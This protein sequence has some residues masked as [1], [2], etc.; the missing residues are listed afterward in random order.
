MVKRKALMKSLSSNLHS[1]LKKTGKNLSLPDKKFLQVGL[2][3]PHILKA[4]IA[5]IAGEEDTA[6]NTMT[7]TVDV[8]AP[9][10]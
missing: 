9:S 2:V 1:F 8:K 6:D 3:G 10:Q 4:E 7:I 5:P